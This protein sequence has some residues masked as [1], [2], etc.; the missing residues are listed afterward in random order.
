MK[1]ASKLII[2]TGASSGIGACT[3]VR[4]AKLGGL[5]TIVDRDLERLCET[6]E[7]CKAANGKTPLV[8]QA[9][10]TNEC[11]VKKI[12]EETVDKY[13]KIDVLFNN[14]GILESGSIEDTNLEQYDRMMNINVRPVYH[15]TMLA[16]PYLIK[17]K[18]NIINTSSVC[19]IRAFPN[20]LAYNMSKAAVAHFTRSVALELGPKGVRV[21]AVNP[22]TIVTNLHRSGGMDEA[23]YK[24][25][26]ERSTLNHALQRSGNVEEVAAAV[27]FLASDSASFITGVNLSVDGGRH[28]MCPR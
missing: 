2:I 23:T 20:I 10:V 1:F 26:L 24:K 5:L 14:A 13:G 25:F 4:F 9:D 15:L 21:N 22:G 11:D 18:G 16:V 6:A 27:T 17:S 8:V 19:G 12:V 28:A 3:A 7:K